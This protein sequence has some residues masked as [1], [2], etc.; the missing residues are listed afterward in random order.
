MKRSFYILATLFLAACSNNRYISRTAEKEVLNTN[1]LKTAHVGI[2]LYDAGTG[3]YIYDYQGDKYFVPA[4]NTKIPTCY[5]AMK[6]LGDSLDG[7]KYSRTGEGYLLQATGDPTLLHSDY[8]NQPV[9][10]FLESIMTADSVRWLTTNWSENALGS[11]WSWNDYDEAYMAERSP[12]P[13]YGNTV[14][15]SMPGESLSVAP[16]FLKDS[17]TLSNGTRS[18]VKRELADNKFTVVSGREKLRA[19]EI[20]YVTRGYHTSLD[21]LNN[22]L[23]R[24]VAMRAVTNEKM[25][26]YKVVH[27]QP[28]DSMLRP[29]MHR[30]DNFFAEQSLL[31]V[32]DRLLGVMSDYRVIDTLLKSALKDLPQPPRWVDGSGLSRY[33]LFSPR[34]FVTILDRMRNDFGMERVKGIFATGGQGTISS[35]Y[36]QDSGYFYAKTGTLSGVVALSGFM[37]TQKGKQLIFSVIVNNHQASATEVRRAVEKFL[38]EVRRRY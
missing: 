26:V 3:Q 33:N 9:Y 14:R 35:Y 17:F 34:D 25:P 8:K 16:A 31:M 22:M 23:K 10:S 21:I 18:S 13:A 15:V 2:A 37:Y 29:M 36:K 1:A 12:L 28:V 7:L 38:Q 30:S 27:S 24:K 4:S 5:V 19:A 6:Y 32:S 20:P 11:G